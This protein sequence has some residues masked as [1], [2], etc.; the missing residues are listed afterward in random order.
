MDF[1]NI[2]A[3]KE[4]CIAEFYVGLNGLGRWG[5]QFEFQWMHPEA[6]DRGQ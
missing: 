3:A 5:E 1:G 6:A 4:A 2:Q